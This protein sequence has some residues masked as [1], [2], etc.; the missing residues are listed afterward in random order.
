[1]GWQRRG[2]LR[3]KAQG[4]HST[5]PCCTAST[6][7]THGTVTLGCNL[8]L[9]RPRP[10]LGSITPPQCMG[11]KEHRGTRQ[12]GPRVGNS[13]SQRPRESPRHEGPPAAGKGLIG[14]KPGEF[15]TATRKSR[16]AKE[17]QAGSGAAGPR[18]HSSSVAV[19]NS[20]GSSA[21]SPGGQGP[22]GR[23]RSG[24]CAGAVGGQR[25]VHTRNSSPAG[26]RGKKM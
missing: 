11:S 23:P 18:P 21:A 8:A 14:V 19:A 4:T 17:P 10:L 6:L 16:P 15:G 12:Q 25:R 24:S 2:P 3:R 7:S 26:E 13:Q 1:M 22:R 20:P 9:P 5:R